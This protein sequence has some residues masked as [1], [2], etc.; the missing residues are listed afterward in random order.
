MYLEGLPVRSLH[1]EPGRPIVIEGPKRGAPAVFLA[2]EGHNT[3]SLRD[4]SHV[5][6]RNLVLDGADRDVDAVKAEHRS[7]PIHHITLEG[8]TIIR[9]GVDQG[10]N[11]I[12]TKTPAAFWTIRN[13]VIIGAGTGMYLGNSDGSEPFVAG[14]IEGNLIVNTVGYNLQ[15]KHQHARPA[16]EGLPTSPQQTIIRGNFFAKRENASTGILARPNLLVGH[17][18]LVGPGS[19]DKYVITENV[20]FANPV[21]SLL[22]GEGNVV[23]S[24]NVMINPVGTGLAVQPHNDVPRRIEV[25]ANFIVTSG[26]G[27]RVWGAHPGYEQVVSRNREFRD[28]VDSDGQIR[29]AFKEWLSSEFAP[30][31]KGRTGERPI[32]RARQL[33]CGSSS[34]DRLAGQTAVLPQEHFLCQHL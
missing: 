7:G 5:V 8:L 10:V 18:P 20:L 9:H 31:R 4:T 34:D 32:D 11:G 26:Q 23:I 33:A 1:G 3:V 2:R 24:R 17:F 27:I 13:N 28:G 25:T 12:S 29:R 16:L 6:I 30:R 14:V 22:Q 21:E 15:I 19:D